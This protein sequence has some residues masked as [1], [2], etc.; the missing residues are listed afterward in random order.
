[1]APGVLDATRCLAVA[2]GNSRDSDALAALREEA[3]DKPSASDPLVREHV[4][5]ALRHA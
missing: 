5:W 3:G 1:M 4:K 2:I